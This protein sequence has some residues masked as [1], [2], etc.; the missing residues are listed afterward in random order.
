MVKEEAFMHFMWILAFAS[1]AHAAPPEKRCPETPVI[2]R[3]S[4]ESAPVIKSRFEMMS[5]LP[6]I[7]ETQI[8][9][10]ESELKISYRCPSPKDRMAA[11][12]SVALLERVSRALVPGAKTLGLR[13]IGLEF[14]P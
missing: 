5:S 4:P 3:A 7:V 13:F 14:I 11:P 1:I 8:L 6:Y 12:D 2:V 9:G 10:K